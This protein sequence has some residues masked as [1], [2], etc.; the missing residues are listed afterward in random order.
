MNLQQAQA[1]ADE[2]RANHQLLESCARHDFQP[3]GG[4]EGKLFPRYG[5]VKCN[6]RVDG[7]A[8]HWYNLGLKHAAN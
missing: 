5:C 2:V 7:H 8:A 4:Q 1:L 6:G 3:E